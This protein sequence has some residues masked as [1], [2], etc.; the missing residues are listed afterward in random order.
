MSSP[1]CTAPD[2]IIIWFWSLGVCMLCTNPQKEKKREARK[3]AHVCAIRVQNISEKISDLIRKHM[4]SCAV[5]VCLSTVCIWSNFRLC[6]KDS[7]NASVTN[8][9]FKHEL[10]LTWFDVNANVESNAR[11]DCVPDFGFLFCCCWKC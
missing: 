10:W 6:V 4:F 9:K 8:S 2:D 3:K 1:I 7:E 5:N 11:F